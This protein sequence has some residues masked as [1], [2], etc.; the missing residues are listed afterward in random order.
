VLYQK[1]NRKDGGEPTREYEYDQQQP[2]SSSAGD[3]YATR[4]PS[5]ADCATACPAGR[6]VPVDDDKSRTVAVHDS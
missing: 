3:V 6:P 5:A 4:V 1:R 2:H